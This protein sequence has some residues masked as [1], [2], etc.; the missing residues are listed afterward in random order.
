MKLQ[1]KINLCKRSSCEK[2]VF[3]D[4]SCLLLLLR[5]KFSWMF[6]LEILG[7]QSQRFS[8]SHRCL[9]CK[10]TVHWTSGKVLSFQIC[11]SDEIFYS[12]KNEWKSK[13]W[14]DRSGCQARSKC[15]TFCSKNFRTFLDLDRNPG[16][17]L[18]LQDRPR[19]ERGEPEAPRR[20]SSNVQGQTEVRRKSVFGLSVQPF[21]SC[22]PTLR[23]RLS[24][25][26]LRRTN[27]FD[28][29]NSGQWKVSS[30]PIQDRESSQHLPV[31]DE[32]KSVDISCPIMKLFWTRWHLP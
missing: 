22:P 8:D 16:R 5:V 1:V 28:N 12:V 21:R 25:S 10:Q 30:L 14:S 3:L 19:D 31:L 2:L 24:L 9:I 23:S 6:Q 11:N 7:L 18:L 15:R 32:D 17:P 20:T 27:N 29:F 26:R 13:Q 4:F